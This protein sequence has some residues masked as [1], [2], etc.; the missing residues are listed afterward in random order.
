MFRINY[1]C[2]LHLLRFLHGSS[3]YV[4]KRQDNKLGHDRF[5]Q[6]ISQFIIQKE[7]IF[8]IRCWRPIT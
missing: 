4:G 8:V 1:D 5:L 7:I 6:H 2:H 3:F